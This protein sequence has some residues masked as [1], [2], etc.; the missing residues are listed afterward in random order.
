[1]SDKGAKYRR[2]GGN[3]LMFVHARAQFVFVPKVRLGSVHHVSL[4]TRYVMCLKRLNFARGCPQATVFCTLQSRRAKSCGHTQQNAV[5]AAVANVRLGQ[6]F[7]EG[8]K[9]C[10]DLWHDG[11]EHDTRCRP[12]KKTVQLKPFSLAEPLLHGMF[13][14][15]AL[16]EMY[17]K[18]AGTLREEQTRLQEE[19]QNV[20]GKIQRAREDGETKRR[21]LRGRMRRS[22]NTCGKADTV[23][24]IFYVS[25]Y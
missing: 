10:F 23:V 19:L 14:Q 17:G 25:C 1:M 8:N 22:E 20:N 7:V 15:V 2:E 5:G 6:G 18:K 3:S 21:I 24:S 13:V 11:D 4:R 9:L 12:E 16:A